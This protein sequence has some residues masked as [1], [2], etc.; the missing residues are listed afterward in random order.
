MLFKLLSYLGCIWLE[1]W[2]NRRIQNDGRIEKWEGRKDFNFP[3]FCLV[4]SEKV[5]GWKK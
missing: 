1:G 3:P 5:E 2:K 4:K